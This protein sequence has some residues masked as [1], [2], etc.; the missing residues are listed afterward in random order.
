MNTKQIEQLLDSCRYE[1]SEHNPGSILI[2]QGDDNDSLLV[3]LEGHAEVW[4][5]T[6]DRAERVD[7]IKPND[8]VGELSFLV[9]GPAT[10]TVRATS[11]C[12]VIRV[13]HDKLRRLWQDTPQTAS[14]L[15]AW[16]LRVIAQ[17]VRTN[18][19][20]VVARPANPARTDRSWTSSVA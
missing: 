10:A 6:S 9:P 7:T 13:A 18:T 3:L 11:R 8:A 16:A 4:R 5:E 1:V 2:R 15:Y 17:R 14:K 19:D 12:I 20:F